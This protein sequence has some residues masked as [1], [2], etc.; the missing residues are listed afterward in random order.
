VRGPR[1]VPTPQSNVPVGGHE[2]D[3]HW[4]DAQL[5]ATRGIQVLRVTW[6]DLAERPES[7]AD[8]VRRVLA[9][10]C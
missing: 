5:V 4:P 9:A 8:E 2:V 10:R 1:R 3:F 7:V 6:W